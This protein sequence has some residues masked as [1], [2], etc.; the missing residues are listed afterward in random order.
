MAF[1]LLG[2]SFSF[3]FDVKLIKEFAF[4]GV[5]GLEVMLTSWMGFQAGWSSYSRPIQKGMLDEP[6]ACFAYRTI[7]MAFSKQTIDYHC[8]L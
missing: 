7:A 1:T 6:A 5:S 8:V 4:I 2:N 3:S